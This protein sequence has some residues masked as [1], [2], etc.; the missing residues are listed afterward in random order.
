ME[1][2]AKEE[3]QEARMGECSTEMWCAETESKSGKDSG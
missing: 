3:E 1:K 2:T